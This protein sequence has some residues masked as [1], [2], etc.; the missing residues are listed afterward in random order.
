MVNTRH[1]TA[2]QATDLLNINASTLYAYVSRGLI[3]SEASAED[4]RARLYLA[5]DVEALRQRKQ[6]R[7]NPAKA[8]KE[9]L[10]WGAPLMESALTLIRDGTLYYRG[11][12]ATELAERHTVEEVA[13]LLWTGDTDSASKL[14]STVP[15]VSAALA[16]VERI[17]QPLTLIQ[18]M[19]IGLTV[20]A[21]SD[22]ASYDLRADNVTKTGARLVH[23]LTSILAGQAV[24]QTDFAQQLADA[25]CPERREAGALFSKALI[26]CADHELNVSAFT[27]RV[28]ASANTPPHQVMVAGLAAMQGLHHGGMTEQA[29]QLLADLHD[30]DAIPHVI[31]GKLRR[32]ELIPGFGHTL[33]PLGDPRAAYLL[34]QL[35][36]A[37]EG[38][39][40]VA[41]IEAVQAYVSGTLDRLPNIDFAL[42]ALT[43]LLNLPVGTGIALF[44]LGRSI[45]WVAHTIEQYSDG[46]LIR[47]RASY[48]GV[49][50]KR[51][52][53]SNT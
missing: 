12:D 43:H 16:A 41:A 19:Q 30:V 14:F 28:V 20:A 2:K 47:P 10:A 34:A 33:Y 13:A 24:G 42:A 27:A 25:W 38:D 18:Q 21:T 36:T 51:N 39:A 15:E 11:V 23:L 50:P 40:R 44:A 46:Q 37:F 52:L 29:E 6:Q 8:I 1:L 22:L 9:S 7:Q 32:G 48:T 45:G 3:R 5:E 53:L 35:R 17:G 31:S 26:L 49:Q 4:T